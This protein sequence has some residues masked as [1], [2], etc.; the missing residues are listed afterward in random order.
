MYDLYTARTQSQLDSA[1]FALQQAQAQ[2]TALYHASI[3]STRDRAANALINATNRKFGLEGKKLGL[4]VIKTKASIAQAAD[5]SQYKWA[6]LTQRQRDSKVR[7]LD[8]DRRFQLSLARNGIAEQGVKIRA[9]EVEARYRAGG[10]TRAQLSSAQK[11]AG[12][13][14][15]DAW[16]GKSTIQTDP[17]TGKPVHGAVHQ[18]YQEAMQEMLSK[19]I[20]LVIAQRALNA[21]WSTPG[22]YNP[23]FEK[24][25]EG[26]PKLS[27]Q[28]R[29][30]INKTTRTKRK[31]RGG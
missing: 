3:A 23:A 9:A 27:F 13:I 4:D 20:P 25:G 14:A 7:A 6:T 17:T 15:H 19:G 8:S 29:Q 2:D 1:K 21:Y 16:S 26:R 28:E 5:T 18:S 30:Q 12:Q 10:Y 22:E 31:K 24:P 11:T